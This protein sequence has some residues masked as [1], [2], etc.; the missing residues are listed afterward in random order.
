[1]TTIDNIMDRFLY[2]TVPPIIGQPEFES[3]SEIHLQL[4]AKAVSVQSHIGNSTLGYLFLTVTPSVLNT[5]SAMLLV[6][7]PN[8]L[9]DPIIP[10]GSTGLQI[11]NI[12]D[13]HARETRVYKLFDST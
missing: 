11:V 3:I 7:S 9:Q 6:L 1:M 2:P 4:N 5:L 8:P 12:C 13:A 10:T